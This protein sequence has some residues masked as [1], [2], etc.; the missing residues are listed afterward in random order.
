MTTDVGGN[1]EV[2]CSQELGII[3]PFDDS[4]KLLNAVDQALKQTWGR[5]YILEYARANSW[6]TRVDIL[7]DEFEKI[8][9]NDKL[10]RK[11][12]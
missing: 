2:V 11:L 12:D 8:V 10:V 3:V 9:N 6:D 5:Q 4:G 1:S 7:I